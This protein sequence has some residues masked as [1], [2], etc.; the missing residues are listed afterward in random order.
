[1]KKLLI[2]TMALIAISTSV[3]A[4]T[5]YRI[6]QLINYDGS[7]SLE[8]CKKH[9]CSKIGPKKSYTMKELEQLPTIWEMDTVYEFM[10]N[11]GVGYASLLACETL[12]SGPGCLFSFTVAFGFHYM[13]NEGELNGFSDRKE[14]QKQRSQILRAT[15]GR[16][17]RTVLLYTNDIEEMSQKVD[18]MNV[19]LEDAVRDQNRSD[20][21]NE[22]TEEDNQINYGA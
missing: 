3:F 16:R 14:V 22:L 9:K 17:L 2:S 18:L 8:Q 10:Q 20:R 15:K 5:E 1:M 4:K 19:M 13:I 11:T 6:Q 12:R 21:L 7:V